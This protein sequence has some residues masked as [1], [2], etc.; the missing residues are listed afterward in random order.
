MGWA[1]LLSNIWV[2]RAA[3]VFAILA[4]L[5][6]AAQYFEHKGA[7]QA[8]QDDGQQVAQA[9]EKSRAADRSELEARL[10]PFQEQADAAKA[11]ADSAQQLFLAVLAQRGAATQQQAGM[12]DAQISAAVQ[13]Q[14]GNLADPAVQREILACKTQLPLCEQESAAAQDKAQQNEARAEAVQGSY[15]ELAG[16]TV[17]LETH[18]TDLWNA[19]S[20]PVRSWKCVKLWRCVRA[21]RSRRRIPRHSGSRCKRL[22][23]L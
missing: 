9:I 23:S 14:I 16:Y 7:E 15:D 12:S 10:K 4:L 6:V 2:R 18:Y 21:R 19:K 17:K 11:K 8:R 1:A 20:T 13:K 5:F 3:I 22:Q